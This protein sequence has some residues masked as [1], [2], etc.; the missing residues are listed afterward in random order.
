MK[1]FDSLLILAC[2][3]LAASFLLCIL[4]V[5]SKA[6]FQFDC[7]LSF[8]MLHDELLSLLI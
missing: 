1:G 4:N 8:H 6:M 2:F 3:E 7:I 5:A